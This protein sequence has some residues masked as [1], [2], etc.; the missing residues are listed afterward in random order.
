MPTLLNTCS[1]LLET[2][3]PLKNAHPS[4]SNILKKIEPSKDSWTA[5]I[6]P[7]FSAHSEMINSVA[8]PNEAFKIPPTPTAR[9]NIIKLE[10]NYHKHMTN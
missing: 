9:Y 2:I 6:I 3:P 1:F 4:T 8:F 10:I 7:L 5:R